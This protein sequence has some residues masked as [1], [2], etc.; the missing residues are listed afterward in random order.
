VNA[1]FGWKTNARLLDDCK[2]W[3]AATMLVLGLSMVPSRGWAAGCKLLPTEMPVTMVGSRAIADIELNGVKAAMIVDSGAFHSVLTTAAA[4]QLNLTVKPMPWGSRVE[5]LTGEIDTG[6]TTVKSLKLLDGE[7]PNVMF[8]VG[9]NDESNG[10][11]GLL[12]RNVLAATDV[13]YDL[14]HGVIRLIFADGDC[15][16][17][18]MAYWANGK[19]FS[20]L[21]LSPD[22]TSDIP[23]IQADAQLNGT[24]V[25][26][27]FDTG[28]QSTVSLRAAKRA[29]LSEADM[30]PIGRIYGAGHGNA[31][32]WSATFKR[33]ELEGEAVSNVR[34]TVADFQE[35]DFDMLIG[36][37]FFLSHRIYISKKQQR[38]YFTYN[39]GPIFARSAIEEAKAVGRSGAGTAEGAAKHPADADEP[40]DAAGYAR[41]G[42]A[43]AARFD[44]AR[45]LADLN[46]ACE[47]APQV[48]EYF[49]RRGV[50]FEAMEQQQSALKDFDRALQLE[51]SLPEA[52]L[53]RATL[54][55]SSAD[56]EGMIEDL[57]A[58]DKTL[59]PQASQRL[60][61]AT[62][63]EHFDLTE[64]ALPQ[65][66]LWIAAHPDDVGTAVVLNNRCWARAMRNIE[67]DQALADCD[68][69]ID[70]EPENDGFYDSRAWLRMRR[71]ELRKALADHDRA[72]KLQPQNAWSLYGRGII[73][74]KL[75][76][77]VA[78]Q[79][80]IDAARK[81]MPSIDED[82]GRYGLA[83]ETKLPSTQGAQPS[84]T[85]GS[86]R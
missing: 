56:R 33:F 31:A 24:K 46:R 85:S 47:M 53:Q 45:A 70:L 55:A 13:E 43:S 28:A 68:K 52:R 77:T 58:L 27:L 30:E 9:G 74:R 35:Q 16:K 38:M 37:D 15:G 78:G 22:D 3:G 60:A 21:D 8:Y 49:L 66:S 26:V 48:A 25:R 12:G 86:G 18:S 62:L 6:F 42:A 39:G 76:E 72:L 1:F 69:A 67:L 4:Q 61:V 71:G 44:F 7:V 11:M 10:T 34:L 5:G 63:Y 64:R 20:A 57:E 80:D 40:E 84:G 79:A 19:P 59:A 73:R 82:A 51:P 65:W 32:A 29:G 36:I 83:A 23:A 41:R 2:V 54:R 81:L 17:A 14:A 75:G 50:V